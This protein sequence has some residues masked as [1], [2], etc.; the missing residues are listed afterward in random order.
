MWYDYADFLKCRAYT[1][2]AQS[3]F[4]EYVPRK[5]ILYLSKH[6]V[7]NNVY[8]KVI[9]ITVH[10]FKIVIFSTGIVEKRRVCMKVYPD[11]GVHQKVIIVMFECIFNV[12]F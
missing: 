3:L 4:H 10:S 12:S 9:V 2:A 1:T 8:E 5:P 7:I 11:R 6:K